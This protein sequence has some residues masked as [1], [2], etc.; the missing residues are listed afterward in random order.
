M[1]D[2]LERVHLLDQRASVVRKARQPVWEPESAL[3]I[4]SKEH[5]DTGFVLLLES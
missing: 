1:R 4:E 2:T 3:Y 5:R